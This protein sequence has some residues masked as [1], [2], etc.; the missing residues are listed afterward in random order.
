[1]HKPIHKPTTKSA[2][3][4]VLGVMLMICGCTTGESNQSVQDEVSPISQENSFQDKP[5]ASS[6]TPLESDPTP[7]IERPTEQDPTAPEATTLIAIESDLNIEQLEEPG[8]AVD[9][10]TEGEQAVENDAEHEIQQEAVVNPTEDADQ[11]DIA[12]YFN[13]ASHNRPAS[14]LEAVILRFI[15][16]AEHSIDIAVYDLDLVSVANT[17]VN[18][19]E[20]GV[21]VR[22]V[23]DNSNTGEEN[24]PA[25]NLLTQAN[26][27]WLDDTADGSKGSGLMHNKFIVADSLRVLSGS[28]NFTMSGVKGDLDED[29]NLMGRGNINN[30]VTIE[31][32]HLAAIFTEEFNQYWGDGPGGETDSKFGLSKEDH[33][34]QTVFTDNESIRVDIQFSP[35]SKRYFEGS[36]LDSLSSLL[37]QAQSRVYIAQ[38]VMSA[39]VIADAMLTASLMGAKVK[40]L[41]DRSFFYRYYSEFLDLKGESKFN[42][43]GEY[44]TDSH[45]GH[46]NNPWE[47]PAEVFAAITNEHDKFHHKYFVIDDL[48]VTGSHN[49]SA[50]G[51]FTNDE[52]LL[53]IHDSATSDKY[54]SEF[55]THFCRA[56]SDC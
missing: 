18:A 16:A 55:L 2:K 17:L 29:G 44:E 56:K 30:L 46:A 13:R 45:T 40:G 25:L 54:A 34:L 12:V 26:L 50:A 52:N 11:G 14:D 20:R 8:N 51:A 32:S 39:Q 10:E 43:K 42:T 53:V 35:Q 21:T 27:P 31:S 9:V 15:N 24:L 38:F 6:P 4:L 41:G 48:V 47:S 3:A 5:P 23:T 33:K 22:F 36:T 1:M 19:Q 49:A 28:T 37:S 7:V